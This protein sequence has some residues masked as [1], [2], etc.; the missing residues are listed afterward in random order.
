M[1]RTILVVSLLIVSLLA[2]I[3]CNRE[4]DPVPGRQAAT[5]P[6]PAASS[7]ATTSSAAASTPASG[8]IVSSGDVTVRNAGAGTLEIDYAEG[9]QKHHLRG[10]SR[11]SG[12]R[13]Y[14][15][16]NGPVVIEVKPGDGSFKVRTP[17]GKLLWK[18]K[19]DTNKIK[20][21]DNEENRDAVEVRTGSKGV[22]DVA[23]IPMMQRAII[24]AELVDRK[25]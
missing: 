7:A 25:Q 23:K 11:E 12:K 3:A 4:P 6:P 22:L 20:V 18:V 24:Y 8:A 1:R 15:L 9:G 10:S 13:K 19:M 5:P 17:D 21:S 2:T 16:D 14:A